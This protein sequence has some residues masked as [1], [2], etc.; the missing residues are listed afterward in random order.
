MKGKKTL[1]FR[2][3]GNSETGLGH[4][5]RLFAL[6]E[7]LKHNFNFEF[8][9]QQD[10]NTEVIPESYSVHKIPQAISLEEEPK[11]LFKI[12]NPESHVLIIDGYQFVSSYQKTLKEIGFQ[13]LYVDDL[14]TYH[15]FADIVVN[16]S[17]AAR[18][19]N[20]ILEPYTKLALGVNY[21]L[22]RPS[23]LE[24]AKR[25]PK[26]QRIDT[27]FVCFGGSDKYNLTSKAT[28]A[29]LKVPSIKNI[30]VVIGAAN[31]DEHIKSIKNTNSSKVVLHQN[32]SEKALLNIMK[33]CNFA[34]AP[35]ST[36]LYELVCVK[37]PIISGFFVDNQKSVYSW[38]NKNHC[39]Y[40][41]GN[42]TKFNFDLVESIILKLN[43]KAFQT[44]MLANQARVIDG[45]QQDRFLNLIQD[46]MK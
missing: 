30:H 34:I 46:L 2:A 5:Y 41:V 12:Y 22:I 6:V 42:L 4:L 29:L 26:F 18:S 20:F 10:S 23:F 3:D 38:F 28:E 33:S 7:M 14:M 21:A 43:Q 39:F 25:N 40:G 19:D 27:A 44:D 16:H 24:I 36:I 13:F 9:T 17:S 37:M 11:W 1:I 8:V 35:T 45:D 32:L 15:M 31:N